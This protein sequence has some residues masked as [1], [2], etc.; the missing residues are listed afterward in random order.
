MAVPATAR[1]AYKA[2][3]PPP[4]PKTAKSAGTRR[5]LLELAAQ[6]LVDRGY[7]AVSMHDIAAAAGLT[8]GAVYGHFRSKGQLLVEVIRWMLAERDHSPTTIEALSDPERAVK[9]MHDQ[10]GR[11]LRL[12]EVDAAAAA[13]HD[14][15]VAAGLGILY[16]ERHARIEE[17][18][19]DAPDPETTAWLVSA[20]VAGI[21]AREAVGLPAPD[22]TR[23][24]TTI[25]SAMRGLTDANPT[26]IQSE[27]P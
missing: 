1:T 19:V 24:S 9:L 2:F 3:V 5:R 10:S 8:K 23:L 7:S 15:D 4:A 25:M 14:P 20:V 21:G 26:A 22:A 27:E 18:M 12:L 6:L 13:R 17:T 11:E 16:R